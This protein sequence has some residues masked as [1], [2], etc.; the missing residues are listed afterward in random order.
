MEAEKNLFLIDNREQLTAY[1]LVG[2]AV[3]NNSSAVLLSLLHDNSGKPDWLSL[4]F[5][6]AICDSTDDPRRRV[7]GTVDS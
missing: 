4:C 5:A 6:A 1:C 2:M 7:K 3:S